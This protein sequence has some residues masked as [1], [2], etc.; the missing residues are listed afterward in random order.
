MS[1]D[2]PARSISARPS[3]EALALHRQGRLDEAEKLYAPRAEGAARQFRRAASARHA[4]PPARQ[5]RRGLPADH[6]GAQAPSALRPMRWRTSRSCCTR[7][8]AAP[9]RWQHSTRRW[10]WRPD[11]LDALNNRGNMLLELE[12]PAEALAA[13][14]ACWRASRGTSR[15]GSTAATRCRRSGGREEALAGIRRGARAAA[16][17]PLALYNRGNALSR[18]R[19]LRAD[20]IAAYDGALVGVPGHVEAL[21]QPRPGAAGAQPASRMRWRATRKAL[22]ARSGQSPTR[23]ST[24]R[25]RCSR[26]ATTARGFEKYEWRWK[27]AGMTRGRSFRQAA[28]ARRIPARRAR[29]SCC[30]PSRGSATPSS[31]SAMRRCWRAPAPRSCSRC[32]RS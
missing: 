32:R 10:R 15:R 17:H 29:P 14:D 22:R 21:D 24:R 13:F 18:A 8:S 26:S 4:Q 25:W 28:L 9:R 30:M 23:I 31:S 2:S 3:S 12:R 20:A 6:R 16:R 1:D 7:S 5:G 11:H 27:R 19:A